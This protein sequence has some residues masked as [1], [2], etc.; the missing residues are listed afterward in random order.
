[1]SGE[2]SLSGVREIE[3]FTPKCVQITILIL[4]YGDSRI[5]LKIFSFSYSSFLTLQYIHVVTDPQF[6]VTYYGTP[7]LE[8]FLQLGTQKSVLLVWN[9]R[10]TVQRAV[11]QQ[12][13]A[14]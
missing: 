2:I 9:P 1:M 8:N 12:I 14:N 7:T 11:D 4:P 10:T 5:Y 13:V 3:I 6:K